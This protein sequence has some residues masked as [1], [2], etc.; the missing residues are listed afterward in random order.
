MN[1]KSLSLD[2]RDKI[3]KEEFFVGEFVGLIELEGDEDVVGVGDGLDF[4]PEL[5]FVLVG[6]VIE[7]GGAGDFEAESWIMSEVPFLDG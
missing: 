3:R 1:W 7:E 5:D 6:V 2:V 4:A